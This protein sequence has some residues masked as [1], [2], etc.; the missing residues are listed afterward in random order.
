[1]IKKS[2]LLTFLVL[3]LL[4]FSETLHGQRKRKP[5]KKP[6]TISSVT[7]KAYLEP[8]INTKNLSEQQKLRLESFR[9][10]WQ[11]VNDYYFDPKFNGLN[12]QKLKYEN[13]LKVVKAE[14]DEQFYKILKD[15]IA[16]LNA[17]HFEIIPPEFYR[18]STKSKPN[19]TKPRAI[20]KRRSAKIRKMKIWTRG[21]SPSF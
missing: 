20:R 21:N 13:E 2:L 10:V 18:K 12:W 9:T 19:P 4:N 7:V 15:L 1:M 14:T 11:T 16:G 8:E 3:F 6:R 17:S 5:V